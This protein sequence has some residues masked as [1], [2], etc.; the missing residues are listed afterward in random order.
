MSDVSHDSQLSAVFLTSTSPIARLNGSECDL[1]SAQLT[2]TSEIFTASIFDQRLEV[3]VDT[4]SK[5]YQAPTE[6]GLSPGMLTPC[7]TID[8]IR[9]ALLLHIVSKKLA[10]KIESNGTEGGSSENVQ[11]EWGK[12]ARHPIGFLYRG[13]LF[14]KLDF[15]M[16]NVSQSGAKLPELHNRIKSF[17]K[18]FEA[19][20]EVLSQ[21]H[22]SE[23]F[24]STVLQRAQANVVAMRLF[25]A[26]EGRD[27]PDRSAM[28]AIALLHPVTD[29]A[30]DRGTFSPKTFEKLG[31]FLHGKTIEVDPG[32]ETLVFDLLSDIYRKFP[33]DEHPLLTLTLRRLHAEQI[34][35]KGQT[36]AIPLGDLLD[37][38]FTKGGLSTVAAGY[39]ALEGLDMS[40]FEFFFKGGA[41]FQLMDDLGDIIEDQTDGVSTVWTKT[42]GNREKLKETMQRFLQLEERFEADLTNQCP[43][44]READ[45]VLRIYRAGFVATLLRAVLNQ[46]EEIKKELGKALDPFLPAPFWRVEREAKLLLNAF[47]SSNDL[48]DPRLRRLAL[49]FFGEGSK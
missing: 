49:S 41:I 43:S 24:G 9:N 19:D 32:Y 29:D 12:L 33:A 11:A 23:F 30:I 40:K 21:K 45:W 14:D 42:V 2:Q 20:I 26:L 31:S 1:A 16:Q 48:G 6:N 27:M 10:S 34:R 17:D 35:S 28:N 3:W 37:I 46:P 15:G 4:L 22:G 13:R 7:T 44:F 25:A 36:E 39:I 18:D 38:S 5:S 8:R 47:T